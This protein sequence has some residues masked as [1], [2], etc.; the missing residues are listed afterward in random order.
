[1]HWLYSILLAQRRYDA[2]SMPLNYYFLDKEASL[3]ADIW[4]V[5]FFFDTPCRWTNE[6]INGIPIRLSMT[7]RLFWQDSKSRILNTATGTYYSCARSVRQSRERSW[8][9]SRIFPGTPNTPAPRIGELPRSYPVPIEL[10]NLP[11]SYPKK[12][13]KKEKKNV[14]PFSTL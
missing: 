8:K 12:K 10:S 9:K 1:M 11:L 2:R 13:E 3:Q 14:S 7:K 4:I 6:V 5:S